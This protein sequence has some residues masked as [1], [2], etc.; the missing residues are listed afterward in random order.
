MVQALVGTLAFAADM[1]ATVKGT[2]VVQVSKVADTAVVVAV[3][4]IV[5]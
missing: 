1:V 5:V 2:S 4:A 3:V